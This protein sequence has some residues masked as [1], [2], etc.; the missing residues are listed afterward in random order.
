MNFQPMTDLLENAVKDGIIPSAAYAVGR[1]R[2]VYIRGCLGDRA[3]YPAREKADIDTLYDLASISKLVS[4]T[5]AALRLVEDGKLLLQDSI[6]RFFSEEELKDAPAGR[7]DIT[8]FDLMTHTSGIVP[9]INLWQRLKENDETQIA[10]E[11]LSSKP[12]CR[13]GEQVYYSCMGFILLRFILERITGKRLDALAKELVFDPLGMA[14]TCYCP[15]GDNIASTEKSPIWGEYIKGVVHDE[16]AWFQGGISGNAG[17]FSNL[18]DMIRF[19]AMCSTRGELPGAGFGTAEGRFLSQRMFDLA[20]KNYTPTLDEGRGLGFHVKQPTPDLS[21][22]GDLYAPG[23]FGH[24]GYTGTS[25]YVDAETGIYGI[26]L[27][28]AVH[29]GR[30]KSRFFRMR[31]AFYNTVITGAQ[32]N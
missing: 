13:P 24:N 15:T 21:A 23:S 5:M 12:V 30:D 32:R 10:H 14:H 31:R 18:E 27:T 22:M 11:I 1:G 2:E 29:F 28:N 7:R 26:L 25:L 8:V 3:V 4:T 17:V 6:W 20:V 19:A 16:N 9:G